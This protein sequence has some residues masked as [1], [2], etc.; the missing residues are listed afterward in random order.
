MKT[1]R[2]IIDRIKERIPVGGGGPRREPLSWDGFDV[3]RGELADSRAEMPGWFNDKSHRLD[4]H[5]LGTLGGGNHFI[6]IQMD[7]AGNNIW[8]MLHLGSRNPGARIAAFYNR[9]AVNLNMSMS[10]SLPDRQ[11]SFLTP[12]DMPGINYVRDMNYAFGYA[13]VNRALMTEIVKEV[14]ADFSPRIEF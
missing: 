14:M 11:L 1:R 3:W 4:V 6:E 5:N 8:L 10:I 2:D 7:T 9:A 13:R 12:D